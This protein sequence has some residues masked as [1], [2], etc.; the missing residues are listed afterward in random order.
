MSARLRRPK[1]T[2]S[3]EQ[4]NVT[5]EI[6]YPQEELGPDDVEDIIDRL[7]I[8]TLKREELKVRVC[9]GYNT[10]TLGFLSSNRQPKAH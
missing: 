4:D 5:S 2:L 7:H 10:Q 3:Q 9:E 1:P 8:G 6:T